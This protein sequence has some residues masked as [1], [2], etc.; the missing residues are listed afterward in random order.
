MKQYLLHARK[1]W[2]NYDIKT[3]IR[4]RQNLFIMYKQNKLYKITLNWYRNYATSKI[5]TAK[6]EYYHKLLHDINK[7]IKKTWFVI[8]DIIPPN[9]NKNSSNIK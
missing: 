1:S 3:T 7:N 6:T 5:R 8:N 4:K 2:I 9:C